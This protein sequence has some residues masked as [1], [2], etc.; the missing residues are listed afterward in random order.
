MATLKDTFNR[1]FYYLRLSITDICNF[2][3]R[4]CLPNGCQ[5]ID[6]NFLTVP[7]IYR[8]VIA[9][10]G[11]GVK[12]IR[13]TGG[14]A[15]TRQNLTEIATTIANIPGIEKLALTTNGYHLKQH[16]QAYFD[17]GIR[18]LNISIDSLQTETFKAITGHD[19]L[20]KTLEGIDEALRIGFSSVKINVVLL[21]GINDNEINDF[22]QYIQNK[23]ISVRYI[24]LMQ[25][26]DNAEYFNTHHLSTKI[27][28]QKLESAGWCQETRSL[29]AG[30][31]IEFSHPDYRG[32]MGLIAPYSPDFCQTCN[33]LRVSSRGALHLCLFTELGYSLRELLQTDEQREALQCRIQNLLQHKPISHFLHQGDTGSTEQL[34]QIGG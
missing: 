6:Q 10:A 2:R 33:R 18:Y 24:E 25:T 3:C 12:K 34:A 13:L 29:D 11:L 1:Q 26:G 21:K 20:E 17:A 9:F 31:A 23:P 15:T 19:R 4:Y 8:L 28:R 27:I 32:R 22:L 30:P 5:I 14:E 7:E 16:A